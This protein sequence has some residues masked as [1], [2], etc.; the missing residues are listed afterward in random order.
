MTI[1]CEW[2]R[3]KSCYWEVTIRYVFS[4][5]YRTSN[6]KCGNVRYVASNAKYWVLKIGCRHSAVSHICDASRF[7]YQRFRCYVL[8]TSCKLGTA[9]HVIYIYIYNIPRTLHYECYTMHNV[10]CTVCYAVCTM[11]YLLSEST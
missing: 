8:C 10:F 7:S 4:V 6:S 11:C 1:E 3:V 5:A 9:Y 2:A